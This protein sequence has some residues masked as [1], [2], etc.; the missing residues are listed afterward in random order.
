MLSGIATLH[1]IARLRD[2]LSFSQ[3]GNS[4]DPSRRNA[5]LAGRAWHALSAVL[6]SYTRHKRG[7]RRLPIQ[8]RVTPRDVQWFLQDLA[9][10]A[11]ARRRD[12]RGTL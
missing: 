11:R 4:R 10:N 2:L 3:S 5:E 8:R 12:L 6:V 7:V 9:E 1:A